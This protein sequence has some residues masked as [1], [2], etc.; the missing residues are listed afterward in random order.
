MRQYISVVEATQAVVLCYG[1]P[2]ELIQVVSV[3]LGEV[4]LNVD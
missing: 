2:G 1:R 4:E 3:V